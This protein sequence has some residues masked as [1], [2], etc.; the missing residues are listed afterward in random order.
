MPA[1]DGPPAA[2]KPRLDDKSFAISFADVEAA[3][4]RLKAS[5]KYRRTPVLRS[6]ALEEVLERLV[7]R[8][9]ELFF[10]C[11]HL[12]ATGSFKIRGAL[13]SLLSLPEEVRC[14]GVVTHSSG[15][16]GQALAL[17]AQLCGVKGKVVVPHNAPPVKVA[18]IQA[19]GAE[20]IFCEP[21]LKARLAACDKVVAE[22]GA[23]VVP[24]YDHETVM[25]G[26]G[27][28]GLEMVQDI[29]GVDAIVIP[30]SG[31]GLIS[32]CAVG[33]KG[34]SDGKVLVFGAEPLG[35]D[36]A[37]QSKQAGKVIAHAYPPSATF[38]DALRVNKLGDRCWPVIRDLVEDILVVPDGQCTE[39]MR[40]V[41]ERMKQVIEPSGA[42]ATA[43]LFTPSGVAALRARPELKRV[44]VLLCGGN[45]D[46]ME[47]MPWAPKPSGDF[48]R[49][50]RLFRSCYDE[51]LATISSTQGS[52]Y[53]KQ[54]INGLSDQSPAL[55]GA[56]L[57][58]PDGTRFE[59]GDSDVAFQLQSTFKPLVYGLSLK[60]FGSEAVHKLVGA[61]V[62][63]GGFANQDT[64]FLPDGR[65]HN[66]L[67]N[68]GA[69]RLLA[70][71]GGDQPQ[72]QD[73]IARVTT[74]MP[75][76]DPSN[77]LLAPDE[78]ALRQTKDQQVHNASLCKTMGLKE[79]D[80][81]GLYA[82]LDCMQSTCRALSC[83]GAK[84]ASGELFG[85]V[86]TRSVRA[87]MLSCGMYESSPDWAVRTG[88]PAKSGVSGVVLGAAD[89]AGG[90][91]KFGVCVFAPPLDA[92]GNSV[93][94]QAL[95]ERFCERLAA[96]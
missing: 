54:A 51:V 73:L 58:L 60:D 26:Q 63:L 78:V 65:P 45:L 10:K 19:Y 36:D 5:P 49:A 21:N 31:G 25:A 18:A 66:P 94:A 61:S 47:P 83:L 42:V 59:C 9:V 6:T 33:A 8:R 80:T 52:V 67:I 23:T 87:V 70:K 96:M 46:L 82:S 37:A 34:A 81:C 72:A 27:T 32:G 43:S 95:L 29:E 69:L 1:A 15:N 77:S 24:P 50:C 22:T 55:F 16:H 90:L 62:S 14:K 3:H 79:A 86:H 92:A 17:A 28:C 44:G 93:R 13:N 89:G 11:E 7:G 85:P 53:C 75:T 4:A 35:A 2:K 30:V 84:M 68:A 76:G 64:S 39:T 38:C 71:L 41:Y 88:L 48:A 57:A 12:Q 56:A 40:L 74:L 91:G 20:V